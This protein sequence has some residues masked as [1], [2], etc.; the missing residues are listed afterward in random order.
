M[1]VVSRVLKLGYNLK[2]IECCQA[3]TLQN[4]LIYFPVRGSE[5]HW[6]SLTK[7]VYRQ[8]SECSGVCKEKLHL[9]ALI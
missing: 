2:I 3:K 6:E 5:A 7:M 9:M 4:G 1:S 8:Q